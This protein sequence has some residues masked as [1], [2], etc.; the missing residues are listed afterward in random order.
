ML[1]TLHKS[2]ERTHTTL[3]KTLE[4]ISSIYEDLFSSDVPPDFSERRMLGVT[5]L[6][7]YSTQLFFSLHLHPEIVN[8][9]KSYFERQI[10][11]D[12][13]AFYNKVYGNCSELYSCINFLCTSE[14]IFGCLDLK[15]SKFLL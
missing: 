4:V 9:P 6:E 14:E 3:Q 5:K 2:V 11:E 1:S 13:K 15:C 7:T 10:G 12:A 8:T